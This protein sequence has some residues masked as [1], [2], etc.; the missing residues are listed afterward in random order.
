MTI[1]VDLGRKAT[2]QTKSWFQRRFLRFLYSIIKSIMGD[3]MAI[4]VPIQ[5]TKKTKKKKLLKPFP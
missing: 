2:Q 5:S 4:R 3:L 1:A